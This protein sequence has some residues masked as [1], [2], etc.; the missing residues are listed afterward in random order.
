MFRSDQRGAQ[1]THREILVLGQDPR[2]IGNLFIALPVQENTIANFELVGPVQS[3]RII[4]AADQFWVHHH[5]GH[6][7]LKV[8]GCT[9]SAF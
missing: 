5:A 7:E 4:Q 8:P 9:P 6:S 2:S 1:N 3:L